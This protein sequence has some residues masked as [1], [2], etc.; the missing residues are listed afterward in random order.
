MAKSIV[1]VL[2][3]VFLLVG[4]LGFFND[5]VLGLFDVDAVHNLVHL[6]T[7]VVALAMA[8]MG[9][10]YA[11]TY[12]KVFGVIYLLVALLGFVMGTEEPL[13][14]VMEN[15]MNDNYLHAL[16]AIVLLWAGFSKSAPQASTM[17][18]MSNPN[19][20]AMGGGM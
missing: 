18:N 11:K 2:G 19:P 1:M 4:L 13:L 16:L 5:P 12:A 3:V 7:G 10:S 14:G 17:G 8:S 20:P 15:N 9:E 6:V